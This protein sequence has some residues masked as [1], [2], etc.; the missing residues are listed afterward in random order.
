MCSSTGV[1][2]EER[3]RRSGSFP[4]FLHL[5]MSCRLRRFFHRESH[6]RYAPPP[7][8]SVTVEASQS[9][10]KRCLLPVFYRAAA[11]FTVTHKLSSL[12]APRHCMQTHR[13]TLYADAPLYT[14]CRRH[15]TLYADVPLYTVC[16]RTAV[17]CMQTTQY[18]VCR[19]HNTLYAD[20]TIHCM[21]TYRCCRCPVFCSHI[22]PVHRTLQKVALQQLF[23]YLTDG[24]LV[25]RSQP[26]CR[27]HLTR[28]SAEFLLL[29]YSV[30]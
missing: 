23:D 21:Q 17:H 18:T 4:S 24:H 14:V 2:Q 22:F 20:D 19:R 3:W 13:C 7:V 30:M 10:P 28:H 8:I 26:A 27:H 29:K 5:W 6:R 12:C 1:G 25:C 15:N 16:R 11:C 9:D